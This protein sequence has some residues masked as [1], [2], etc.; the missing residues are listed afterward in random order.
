M[1]EIPTFNFD[2]GNGPLFDLSIGDNF[3]QIILLGS[4]VFTAI[5]TIILLIHWRKYT[6]NPL[7]TFMHTIVYLAGTLAIIIAQVTL[8]SL[9]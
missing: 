2:F 8:L 6:P 9:Y 7:K 1:E 3:L 5:F 4:L